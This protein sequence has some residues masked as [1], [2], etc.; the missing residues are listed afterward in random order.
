M[1]HRLNAH[2]SND[3]INISPKPCV[4]SA[5]ARPWWQGIAAKALVP[6]Q[7]HFAGPRTCRRLRICSSWSSSPSA[8]SPIRQ[9]RL[10]QGRLVKAPASPS[11]FRH[12]PVCLFVPPHRG[13]ADRA[14]RQTFCGFGKQLT[15]LL[16]KILAFQAIILA[17]LRDNTYVLAHRVTAERIG[18]AA[19]SVPD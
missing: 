16:A 3:G 7:Y 19:N 11:L 18:L 2:H 5:A 6:R 8:S 14:G 12:R 15:A 10:G 13:Q 9:R 4:T 1:K 17:F